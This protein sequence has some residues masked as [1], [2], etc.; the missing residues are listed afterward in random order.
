MSNGVG[1]CQSEGCHKLTGYALCNS[2]GTLNWGGDV[3]GRQRHGD[4]DPKANTQQRTRRGPVRALNEA[5]GVDWIATGKDLMRMQAGTVEHYAVAQRCG[6][7]TGFH[8]PGGAPAGGTACLFPDITDVAMT[9]DGKVWVLA[10]GY[11]AI[12]FAQLS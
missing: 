3:G 7:D 5:G 2:V 6:V 10:A 9:S 11:S 12:G 4:M 8:A 1:Y